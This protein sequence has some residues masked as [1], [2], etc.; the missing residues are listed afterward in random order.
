[1]IR[2]VDLVA[3]LPPFMQR[4][5]EPAAALEAENPEFQILWDA[6]DRVLKNGFIGTADE[7]GL[8]RFERVLKI[9]PSKSDTLESRRARIQ[10]RWVRT[11]PYTE[12]VLVE[13]LAI[14]CQGSH[15]TLTKRYDCYK[16]EVDVSL[17]LFGQTQELERILGDMIPCNMVVDIRNTL[18]LM[19]EGNVWTGGGICSIETFFVTNDFKERFDAD[20]ICRGGSGVVVTEFFTVQN[21]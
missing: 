6:A 15:F 1:M 21:E 10:A 3:C 12:R 13:K 7:D 4:Y 2:E 9:E 8:S 5:K 17:E 18:N 14:L 11:I 20:G 19:A 16:I